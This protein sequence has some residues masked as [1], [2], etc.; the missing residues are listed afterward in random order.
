MSE[1]L[2]ITNKQSVL[3]IIEQLNT[4]PDV[5]IEVL[6]DF[7]QGLKA[8]FY[9]L[10]AMVL[11]QGEIG[12]ITGEKVA[13][14]V[15]TLLEGEPIRLLLLRDETDRWDDGDSNF[16]GSIDICLPF[17]ELVCQFQQQLCDSPPISPIKPA[18]AEQYPQNDMKLDE[19]TVN[20]FQTGDEFNIDPFADVFPA[21][22][23]HDWGNILPE[24]GQDPQN[25]A[26]L[27][28]LTVEPPQPADEFCFDPPSDLLSAVPVGN[29]FS[30]DLTGAD[31]LQDLPISFTPVG[32]D[33]LEERILLDKDIHLDVQESADP[34]FAGTSAETLVE[35]PEMASHQSETGGYETSMESMLRLK[36]VPARSPLLETAL[37]KIA[38]T[39]SAGQAETSPSM[40]EEAAPHP[41]AWQ[42]ASP[43]PSGKNSSPLGGTVPE[44]L[45][46]ISAGPHRHG[47]ISFREDFG[48]KTSFKQK[49]SF[50]LIIL[51]LG[52]ATFLLVRYWENPT[53]FFRQEG[54]SV[55]P[56]QTAPPASVQKLPAFIPRGTPDSTYA[57][58]H[59]GWERYVG[60]GLEYLVCRENN[61]IRAIQVIAGADGE[62]SDAFLKMCIR[63]TTGREDCDNWVRDKRDNFLVEKGTLLNK[64]ELAV[65]RKM[66]EGVI[67]GFV[68]SFY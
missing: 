53:G 35:A 62:I 20:S 12:G 3:D 33:S 11:I 7:T 39:E 48:E 34:L 67:R 9:R 44:N 49:V 15:K 45:N 47:D 27:V 29:T 61:R 43:P 14:Q 41:S 38:S 55:G 50:G 30:P 60:N 4:L 63:Q 26:E 32:Q 68:L 66:P 17:D 46:K 10:P 56:S 16:D 51:I 22:I 59:P 37:T 36:E 57:A 13:G 19:F 24:T 52:L 21:H 42:P 8:I 25:E 23:R 54:V 31:L 40:T 58:A 28:E 6:T 64:G 1:I 2:A 18:I 65:Y 5:R